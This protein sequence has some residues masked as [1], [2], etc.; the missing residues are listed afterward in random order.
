MSTL[1]IAERA[2]RGMPLSDLTVIDAHGHLGPSSLVHTAYNTAEDL[3]DSM[4]RIGIRRAC[5]SSLLALHVDYRRGNDQMAEIVRR[6]PDR[7]LGYAVINPNYPEAIERELTR[8]LDTLGLG[9][10]K[11]HPSWHAYPADGPAYQ[12]VYAYMNE[13]GGVILSHTFDSPA[14]LAAISA[15][16]PNVSFIHAHVGGGHDGRTPS[17]WAPLLRDRDNV[18]LDT[19]LSVVS[20][21]G[22]EKLVE[23]V[24][25]DKL[26]FGTDGAWMDNAH[27]IGR[28]TH[29]DISDEDKKKIL[30]LNMQRILSRVGR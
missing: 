22:I 10:V 3:L 30:G 1:T 29:A 23:A 27:Q 12:R 28:I 5:V 11:I 7:I 14:V 9:A 8:G 17:P 20:F 4:N 26:L 6:Y 2:S 21:G 19:V 24:G 13:R 18:Y 15:A 16:Y 25:A